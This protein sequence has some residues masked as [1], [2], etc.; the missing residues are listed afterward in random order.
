MWLGSRPDWLACATAALRQKYDNPA[1]IEA[2][3]CVESEAQLTNDCLTTSS[4]GSPE[5]DLCFSSPLQC[6]SQQIDLVLDLDNACPDFSLLPR[7]KA[8]ETVSSP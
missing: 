8:N 7:Q 2:L 5:R 6:L 1:A 4:C 3:R